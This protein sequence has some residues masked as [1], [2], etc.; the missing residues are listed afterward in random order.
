MKRIKAM[1]PYFP[2]IVGFF[3]FLYINSQ[4]V[5][6]ADDLVF[7]HDL[8]HRTI[9]QWCVEFYN[10]WGGRVPLLLLNV[11]FLYQPLI[12]WIIFNSIITFLF[13]V[14][15]LKMCECFLEKKTVKGKLC[16]SF[17]IL[18]LFFIMP[19]NT[20]HDGAIWVTGSFNYLLPCTML[21][22]GLYPFFARL[23]GVKLNKFDR[24]L[25]F[26]GVFLCCYEEQT[27]AIFLCMSTFLL[28]LQFVKN[29]K[30][31]RGILCLY[32]FGILNCIVM[33]MAPG[34]YQ[35]SQSE[36][37]CWYPS[38]DTYN[39]FDKIVLGLVHTI[40]ILV[41]NGRLYFLILHILLALFLIKRDLQNI[42]GFVILCALSFLVYKS[43]GYLNDEAVWQIYS[44]KTIVTISLFVFWILYFAFFL[45]YLLRDNYEDGIAV[46]LLF[47]ATFVAGIVMGM[48]PTVFASGLRVFFVSYVLLIEISLLL[49]ITILNRII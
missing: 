47:L 30:I 19:Q 1:L 5:L 7:N 31:D 22:V 12:C 16:L 9:I 43:S 26:I 48:S 44:L 33:F 49:N 36:L 45:F 17:I 10:Q 15:S 40:K 21:I 32:V 39:L 20:F 8:D 6:V 23:K 35:R 46:A 13:C 41:H 11:F 28:I 27:A 34:N 4:T 18:F 14:Y 3:Y 24:T 38:F 25:S 37:I 29:K 2:F 42:F